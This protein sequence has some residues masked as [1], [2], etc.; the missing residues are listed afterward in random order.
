VR[1]VL[2]DARKLMHS[3]RGA[4]QQQAV[5]WKQPKMHRAN[6]MPSAGRAAAA[7]A[8]PLR[9]AHERVRRAAPA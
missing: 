4:P 1:G 2:G 9:P 7:R 5:T 8:A 6:R 3:G